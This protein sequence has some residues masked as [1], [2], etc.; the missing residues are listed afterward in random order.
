[1]SSIRSFIAR[2]DK[3]IPLACLIIIALRFLP[4]AFRF[5]DSDEEYYFSIASAISGGQN[6]YA[7]SSIFPYPPLMFYLAS[8]FLRLLP[9]LF[10][11][12]LCIRL[13][14]LTLSLIGLW[15]IFDIFKKMNCGFF[16][17]PT[18][19]MILF[20]APMELK[21]AEFRS[22]NLLWLLIVLQGYL[23]FVLSR[24]K[25][26]ST[27]IYFSIFCLALLS[28]HTN[29][30]AVFLE[31]PFLLSFTLINFNS[32]K[33][34]INDFKFQ[35]IA[36]LAALTGMIVFSTPYRI[37]IY[38]SY[39]YPFILKGNYPYF[40]SL[41]WRDNLS[42]LLRSV[43]D[44]TAFW[45]TGLFSGLLLGY[46]IKRDR[47]LLVPFS[48]MLGALALI[49]NSCFTVSP[50]VQYQFYL[51]W[52]ILFSLP[53]SLNVF[54]Q[55][56]PSY[57]YPLLFVFLAVSC[58]SI[59]TYTHYSWPYRDL[60]GYINTAQKVKEIV[61][62][63]GV[64]LFQGTGIIIKSAVPPSYD[65]WIN[66][67]F[68]EK[69]SKF[70]NLE[71]AVKGSAPNFVLLDERE[72]LKSFLPDNDKRFIMG[73]YQKCPALPLMISSKWVILGREPFDPA[74]LKKD[75]YRYKIFEAQN[76][77]RPSVALIEFNS[78]KI[79]S[80]SYIQ[81][82]LSSYRL[83]PVEKNFADKFRLLYVL[84]FNG[85]GQRYCRIFWEASKDNNDE[86]M[87]F[88]HLRDNKGN[89]IDGINVDPTD[90][91]YDIGQIKRGEIISY[92]ISVGQNDKSKSLDIG[93]YFK[94][95]WNARLPLGNLTFYRLYL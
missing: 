51:I 14:T 75:G 15:L 78:D 12:I 19:L 52:A 45:G 65:S 71:Q 29:Q 30:K 27:P 82:N 85:R 3:Y 17:I 31:I 25:K 64:I 7:G 22:D 35:L 87:A 81:S 23:A 8:L 76:N 21:I 95:D 4:L 89:Y 54:K 66:Y 10:S 48:L 9:D 74:L 77:R 83:I 13:F 91:W 70:N 38:Q 42:V 39:I 68:V 61:G 90:G 36:T 16:I 24:S 50:Y 33:S 20:S 62:S 11:A 57:R 58:L 37:S 1:M 44:Y 26:H 34:F 69:R 88:H 6:P 84:I 60:R 41:P 55:L 59:F 86:L 28:F 94:N 92:G 43:R 18:T 93:W 40:A 53:F 2:I 47:F 32:I 63:D 5:V 72:R 46:Q 67:R 79:S 49:I 56:F 80:S 73:N